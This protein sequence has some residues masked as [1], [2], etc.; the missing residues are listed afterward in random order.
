MTGGRLELKRRA[1][2]QA[3]ALVESGM[4][5]GLGTG[6]TAELAVDALG[7]KL[8]QG[9][10]RDIVGIPTSSRTRRHAQGLG[11]P[12]STLDEHPTIDLTI[13]GADE[14]DPDG[15]L[16]KGGGGALLWE[17][18]VASASRRYAI[19]IDEGKLVER[20]GLT[21]ALPVEVVSFGWR[22]HVDAARQLGADATLRRDEDGGVFRTDEGHFIL[23]CRFADGIR[24][25][26]AVHAAL[27]SRPGVVETGLF[28]DMSPQVF[29]GRADG[30]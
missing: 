28:L 12:L 14:V 1:A 30:V 2:F 22:T 16:I 3:V 11:I 27:R 26:A 13:D 8:K 5:V 21:F 23:D 6:S 29:V 10:L 18:I 24:D 15:N 7:Q 20:L 25:P 4:V 9:L 19:V 17:K